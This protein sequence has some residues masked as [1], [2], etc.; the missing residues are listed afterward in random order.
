MN[1]KV[2]EL[3]TRL[4]DKFGTTVEHLWGVLVKQAG[5]SAVTELVMAF[6]MVAAWAWLFRFVRGKTTEP[7][8]TPED[9]YPHAEWR[10]EDAL[11][12]WLV[13][14]FS[15]MLVVLQVYSAITTAPTALFNP[16]YWA[17]KQLW[18]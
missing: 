5:I 9:R 3:L 15:L 2:I 14:A 10:E 7:K 17:L 18:P 13:A 12:A 6:V 1:D 11:I 4:A 16:E 8:E